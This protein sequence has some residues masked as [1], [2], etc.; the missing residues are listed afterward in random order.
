M[1]YVRQPL[2]SLEQM[3]V[4]QKNRD[5]AKNGEK[6]HEVLDA[7]DRMRVMQRDLHDLRDVLR[8]KRDGDRR[9]EDRVRH[10]R[11]LVRRERHEDEA[12]GKSD[13]NVSDLVAMTAHDITSSKIWGFFKRSLRSSRR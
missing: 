6:E 11:R 1:I 12:D 5:E 7:P 13:E 3:K 4:T 8:E 10:A 2:L 9:V